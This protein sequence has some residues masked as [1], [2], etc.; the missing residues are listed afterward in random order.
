MKFRT[1]L[2]NAALPGLAGNRARRRP[3]RTRTRSVAVNPEGRYQPRVVCQPDPV[4]DAA[5]RLLDELMPILKEHCPREQDKGLELPWPRWIPEPEIDPGLPRRYKAV[6]VVFSAEQQCATRML[7]ELR[8]A[9]FRPLAN[10]EAALAADP[11]IGPRLDHVVSSMSRGGGAWQTESLIRELVDRVIRVATLFELPPSLRDA[12]T[13]HWAEELRRPSDVM[14]GILALHEFHTPAAPIVLEPGLEIVELTDAEVAAA[15]VLAPGPVALRLDE[16]HVSKVF[17]IRA[18]YDSILF[19]D[20]IPATEGEQEMSVRQASRTRLERALLALRVFKAGRLRT[21]GRFEYSVSSDGDVS[22]ARGSLRVLFASPSV[23]SYVLADEDAIRFSEF[24]AAF[25]KVHARPVI[26]SALRRFGFAADRA[27]PDDEIVDLMIAAEALFLS[28]M[29]DKYRGELRFRLS[30]RAA[31]LLGTTLDERLRLSKFMRSAY[32][33]RSAVVH[34]K[35]LSD[36]LRGLD[37]ERATVRAFADD[38]ESV[39]R[40]AL[41]TAIDLLASEQPFPPNWEELMFASPGQ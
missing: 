19:I 16:R 23:K 32:D 20:D 27:L 29:E 2:A 24:W 1:P 8:E 26:A 31:S 7:G 38:L 11:A 21:S 28:E 33:A 13:T 34:G 22:P 17:G 30:I 3:H 15:L 25:D 9:G 14:T 4:V 35:V 18:S 39:L 37:G 10:L 40:D 12:A 6:P 5:R 41:Q 36:D